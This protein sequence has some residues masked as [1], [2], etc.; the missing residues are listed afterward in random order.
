MGYLPKTM[1]LAR[2]LSP[3]TVADLER[4]PATW[5]GEIIDGVMHAVPRPSGPHAQIE[6]RM[7]ADLEPPFG[8]GR[9][10]PGGWW[11]VPEPG[12]RVERS[13]EFS[14]DLGGWKRDRLPL[15]PPTGPFTTVPDWIC[16][17]LSPGTRNYDLTVKRRFYS[18]IGVPHLWYVDVDARNLEV[19]R[20]S[21]GKWLELATYDADEKVRAE[22]FEAIEIDLS[23]WWADL[24]DATAP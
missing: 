7:A 23:S 2:R 15:I 24:P 18:E 9:G 4:L 11:I 6:G 3:A 22:P 17:I 13:P 10:G 19:S 5:R 8:R 14:P 12:I 21:D 1:S 16:E 20:L